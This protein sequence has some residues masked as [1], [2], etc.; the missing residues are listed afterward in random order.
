VAT[1][2]LVISIAIFSGKD[3]SFLYVYSD[4]GHVQPWGLLTSIFPHVDLIHLLFN[5][6]WLWVFGTLVEAVYGPAR[7]AAIMVLFAVGSSAAEFALFQGGIG[8]SGVGYGLF[9]LLWVLSWHDQRFR[10]G[11]DAQTINLFV[12]WFFL[13]IFLTYTGVW[14]VG[15]V[16]HGMGALLGA[17]LGFC[18]VAQGSRRQLAQATLVLVVAAD[19]LLAS[20]GRSYVNLDPNR[21]QLLARLGYENLVD[22]DYSQAIDNLKQALKLNANDADSW[23]NLGIAY[24]GLER[25]EEALEAYGRACKLR[26]RSEQFRHAVSYSKQALVAQAA[27]DGRFSEA[28]KLLE[29]DLAL[30]ENQPHSWFWLATLYFVLENREGAKGALEHAIK[31]DPK[32]TQ[33]HEMLDILKKSDQ[34]Q[35]K[36]KSP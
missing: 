34:S 16:A 1:L 30:N 21:P 7:T 12:V 11:V 18:I 14:R 5:L 33:Y 26:P 28:I 17:L 35:S 13:C 15:N 10:G 4:T 9:G 6:Y 3:L 22:K 8:L 27:S 20:Y 24:Q 19:L 36:E 32:N 25:N 31:L 2:A 23:Y 29:E